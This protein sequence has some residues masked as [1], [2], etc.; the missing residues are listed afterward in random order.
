MAAWS[1]LTMRCHS[2]MTHK[3]KVDYK[4]VTTVIPSRRPYRNVHLIKTNYVHFRI[5][6]VYHNTTPIAEKHTATI[7]ANYE[8]HGHI[9]S[10]EWN[11]N[12]L[13]ENR[14][15]REDVN[16][17]RKH[18]QHSYYNTSFNWREKQGSGKNRKSIMSSKHLNEL[19]RHKCCFHNSN[20]WS[21]KNT[22]L[23]LY[24][25]KVEMKIQWLLD[26]AVT[27]IGMKIIR[28]TRRLT[29][30]VVLKQSWKVFVPHHERAGSLWCCS[31]RKVWIYRSEQLKEM[32]CNALR[33]HITLSNQP[34]MNA[35]WGLCGRKLSTNGLPDG[36]QAGRKS[37]R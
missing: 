23:S 15:L 10:I 4:W 17:S 29:L 21:D 33:H 26:D 35:L 27:E 18:D 14:W 12:Y 13:K 9:A 20:L 32:G 28:M 37:Y 19:K 5:M 3:L 11:K 22:T 25:Q 30:S 8:I 24:W 2:D 31:T 1:H 36:T 6:E 16:S 34:S 7:K